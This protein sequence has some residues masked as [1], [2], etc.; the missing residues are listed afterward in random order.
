MQSLAKLFFFAHTYLTL[1]NITTFF[2]I[3]SF[4][5]T[6]KECIWLFFFIMGT[7]FTFSGLLFF[8]K[9]EFNGSK[10]I[11]IF[12]VSVNKFVET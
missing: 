4:F 1:N 5:L 2:T 7:N 10:Y 12:H 6:F 3:S 11:Y 8:V 9:N